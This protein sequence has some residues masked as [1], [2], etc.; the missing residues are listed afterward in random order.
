MASKKAASKRSARS[1]AAGKTSR[2]ARAR[3][4]SRVPAAVRWNPRVAATLSPPPR[5]PRAF[6]DHVRAVANHRSEIR[7]LTAVELARPRPR[8][9][10]EAEP[11]PARVRRAAQL[12]ALG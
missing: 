9:A 4:A 11:T 6:L 5:E 10:K 8:V 7:A 1:E 3:G 2:T 12:A